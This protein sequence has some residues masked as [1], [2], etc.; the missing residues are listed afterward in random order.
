MLRLAILVCCLAIVTG[1]D[2]EEPEP[3]QAL[4]V[5]VEQADASAEPD[6][7]AAEEKVEP[8]ALTVD[9]PPKP[10]TPPELSNDI[11]AVLCEGADNVDTSGQFPKCKTCPYAA[12]TRYNT[13][14]E[15]YYAFEGS[16]SNK[17]AKELFVSGPGCYDAEGNHAAVLVRTS[18]RPKV[19]QALRSTQA[20][21]C[22]PFDWFGRKAVACH[23]NYESRG[24]LRKLLTFFEVLDEKLKDLRVLD[25]PVK[26]GGCSFEGIYRR[27]L[28]DFRAEAEGKGRNA[29][30]D[31]ILEFDAKVG[32]RKSGTPGD[33]MAIANGDVEVTSTIETFTVSNTADSGSTVTRKFGETEAEEIDVDS[34]GKP[35][36]PTYDLN[37]QK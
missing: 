19:I 17:R 14:W 5:E 24:E 34:T 26:S 6:E 30:V 29:V 22:E 7:A 18:G 11:L 33:C 23:S 10:E 21:V 31:V 8:K 3:T 25:I 37:R 15:M 1:C 16:F 4:P 36:D 9:P 2:K 35:K 28:K 20:D 32:N 27:D 13:E 12:E